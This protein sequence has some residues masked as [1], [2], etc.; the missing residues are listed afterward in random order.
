MYN[1]NGYF[2]QCAARVEAE[3]TRRAERIRDT[4]AAMLARVQPLAAMDPPRGALAP[5]T[6]TE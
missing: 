1:R 2:Q 4:K 3:K 6:K 5:T